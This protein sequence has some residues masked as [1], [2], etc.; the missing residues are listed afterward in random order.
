MVNFGFENYFWRFEWKIRRKFH[1]D[2]E[3]SFLVQTI[4]LFGSVEAKGYRS[5]HYTMPK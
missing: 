4:C 2:M 5:F 1:R 3:L